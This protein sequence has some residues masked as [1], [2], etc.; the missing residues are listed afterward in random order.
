MPLNFQVAA[1]CSGT[2]GEVSRASRHISVRILSYTGKIHR[3]HKNI[4]FCFFSITSTEKLTKILTYS[5]DVLIL[6]VYK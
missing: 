6:Y 4:P 5:R 2:G 1:P 3:V